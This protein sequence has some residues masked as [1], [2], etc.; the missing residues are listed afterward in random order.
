MPVIF[1]L[2][3]SGDCFSSDLTLDFMYSFEEFVE[4]F[5]ANNTERKATLAKIK[6]IFA[7]M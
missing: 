5:E 4:R 2:K 3:C 6:D 1:P 7:T